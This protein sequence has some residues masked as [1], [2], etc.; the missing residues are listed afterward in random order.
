MPVRAS[1]IVPSA[2]IRTGSSRPPTHRQLSRSTPSVRRSRCSSGYR[3]SVSSTDST[4]LTS[5]GSRKAL[6]R[7]GQAICPPVAISP[8]PASPPISACVVDTGRP[9]TVAS[10]TVEAAPRLTASRNSGSSA[11]ASGTRPLPLK[12]S[13]R[14]LASS[15]ASSEPTRVATVAQASARR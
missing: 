6:S 5:I 9:V 7:A 13:T 1:V 8:A 2:A 14:P 12:A 15:S 10:S 3:P 11:T 4:G